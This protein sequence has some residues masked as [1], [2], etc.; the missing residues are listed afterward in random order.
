MTDFEDKVAAIIISVMGGVMLVYAWYHINMDEKQE[1]RISQLES[2]ISQLQSNRAIKT[3]G[4]TL[5]IEHK[6]RKYYFEISSTPVQQ[7][8]PLEDVK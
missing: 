5:Y 8:M 6:G 1:K 3:E 2:K 4:D 7:C